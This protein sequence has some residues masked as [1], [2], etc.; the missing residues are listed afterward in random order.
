MVISCGR[1]QPENDD[2]G[3]NASLELH[4][5]FRTNTELD[6]EIQQRS[7]SMC[8]HNVSQKNN[9]MFYKCSLCCSYFFLCLIWILG[10]NQLHGCNSV[11]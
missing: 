1:F 8:S 4:C 3:E 5:C 2:V 7:N 11:N 9:A 6:A 10:I